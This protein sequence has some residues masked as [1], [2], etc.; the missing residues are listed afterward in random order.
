[1]SSFKDFLLLCSGYYGFTIGIQQ[2]DKSS[3]IYS[4]IIIV[5]EIISSILI[6]YYF[7]PVFVALITFNTLY[8]IIAFH[9]ENI[10]WK[11]INIIEKR[12]LSSYY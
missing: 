7:T 11:N 2:F 8:D 6:A 1:M 12:R 10:F 4:H 3:P 9:M 5:V